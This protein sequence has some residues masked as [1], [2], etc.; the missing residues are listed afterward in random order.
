[1]KHPKLAKYM[2]ATLIGMVLLIVYLVIIN[3]LAYMV[4]TDTSV[5]EMVRQIKLDTLNR[6]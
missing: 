4:E 1:M 3:L 6:K 5:K 2:L